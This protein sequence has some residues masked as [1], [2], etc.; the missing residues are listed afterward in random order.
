MGS[1]LEYQLRA[2]GDFVSPFR[3]DFNG[4]IALHS[5]RFRGRPG[6]KTQPGHS[7]VQCNKKKADR[8]ISV[9]KVFDTN[10]SIIYNNETIGLNNTKNKA[11]LKENIIFVGIQ[12]VSFLE[13]GGLQWWTGRGRC[14]GG[15]SITL[16]CNKQ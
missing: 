9:D 13:Y 14:F 4:P 3:L 8:I 11:K 2:V 7:A 1:S 10:S 6:H 15:L 16:H 12:I 5:I